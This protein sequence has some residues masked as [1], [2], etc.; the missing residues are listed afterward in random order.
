MLLT[1]FEH[2]YE[3]QGASAC[4]HSTI[5]RKIYYQKT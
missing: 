1:T 2:K 4:V 3:K 5:L